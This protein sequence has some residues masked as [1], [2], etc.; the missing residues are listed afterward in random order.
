[1]QNLKGRIE[2]LE[3]RQVAPRP[4]KQFDEDAQAIYVSM[5]YLDAT[6]DFTYHDV[7]HSAP[8]AR[9]KAL[10]DSLYGPIIPAHLD[11]RLK[12]YTRAS[13]EFELAFG[14]EP[15]P[16]DILRYEHV[17]QMRSQ[18][19]YAKHFGRIIAAWQ[20]QLPHL[21]CPLKLEEW[22]LLR[23]LKPEKR[24]AEWKW[25]EDITIQPVV[26]WVKIPEIMLNTDLRQC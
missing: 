21:V 11:Q 9:G 2:K 12:R 24:G 26:R 15:Q 13:G 22:R 19:I 6:T 5:A 7:E 8:Y 4:S 20:R 10:R 18:E 3:R 16:G 14:R 23:R 1:M 17:A 25:E